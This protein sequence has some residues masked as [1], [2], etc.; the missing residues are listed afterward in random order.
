MIMIMATA[1]IT[2]GMRAMTAERLD[3]LRDPKEIY[4]RS[5]EMIG[6]A[7]DLD[8]F[9]ADVRPVA[10][11]LVHASG[12]ETAA[13]DLVFSDGAGAVGRRALAAGAPIYVDAEMVAAGIIQKRLSGNRVICTLNDEGIAH[14]A[15]EQGTTRSAAA[16]ETWQNKL[17]DCPLE[18]S[19]VAIGNA[20]T[21]LFRLLEGI[22]AG[23]PRPALVLG[24]P[25]GFVGAAESKDALIKYGRQLDLPFIT[26]TGR[27]G[28]S[29]MAAAAVNA[30]AGGKREHKSGGKREHKSGGNGE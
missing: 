30:L 28:G 15:A 27:M 3:Y 23:W 29:A 24:F 17:P 26:L 11:R 18:G 21:A 9:P 14:R 19:V 6:A 10:E 12:L 7:A 8:R 22:L 20:P 1:T 16:V 4:R 13:R 25:V 5:F 2:T